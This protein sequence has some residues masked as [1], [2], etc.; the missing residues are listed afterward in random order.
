MKIIWSLLA[1]ERME[2]IF[3]YIQKENITAAYEMIDRII[4][5]V[6]SLS[7]FPSRGRKIPES[8]SE[9]IREVFEGEYRIIYR[10]SSRRI[11]ILSIRNFK[12]LLP[13]K[14]LK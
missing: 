11:F 2:N 8:N 13:D 5:K 12:Q 7:D 1:V 3:E 6:E 4:I 14:D 9:N 10:I